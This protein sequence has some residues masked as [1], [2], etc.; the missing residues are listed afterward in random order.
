MQHLKIDFVSDIA[1]PWCAVGLSS[2]EKA[3]QDV[4]GEISAELH[5]QPFELNP[6]MAPEGEDTLAH[7]SAKYGI[8]PEQIRAN[9][10]NIRA[11]GA[12]VGFT[13]GARDRIWNT[14]NNHRLL[15]W[16]GVEG[17][18]GSQRALKHALLQAYHGDGQ[19]PS[20]PDVLV[21][22]ACKAGLDGQRARAILDGDEFAAEVRQ[23]EAFW[24]Q[25]GIRAVPSVVINGRHL[26]QGGQPPEAFEQALRQSFKPVALFG[27][28]AACFRMAHFDQ[29]AHFA[30]DCLSGRFRNV[31]LLAHGIA[32]EHFFLVLAIH[33]SAQ[34]IRE[35][36]ARDHGARQFGGLLDV[37]MR[38]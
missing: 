22:A 31:L 37:A 21:A 32:E 2:L 38:A 15:Y 36:P 13:F 12:A 18:A 24:Q 9:Q 5:F 1:C 20:D 29:A 16:A 35:A 26:I 34:R 7:L 3:L 23:A 30:I 11:R 28:D 17:P 4:Q 6:A 25:A 8:G 33:H 10:A 19:N 27:D 14:F